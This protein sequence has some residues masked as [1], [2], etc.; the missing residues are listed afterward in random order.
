MSGDKLECGECGA[1]MVLRYT[2]RFGSRW[3]Y[4]CSRFPKCKGTHSCHQSTKEPMG[5]PANAETKLARME[6][7]RVFDQVWKRGIMGRQSAYAWL[8][9]TLGL[10]TEECHIG[11]FGV[12][13]C[14]RVVEVSQR[15]L[16]SA[17]STEAPPRRTA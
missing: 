8:A 11:L 5:V 10:T 16:R 3:F 13:Q 14:R 1:P 17:S 2:N 7:H 9:D 4:G 15:L 12:E 6:A